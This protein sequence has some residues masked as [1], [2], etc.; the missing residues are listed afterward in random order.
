MYLQVGQDLRV[1]GRQ[2]NVQSQFVMQ[3]DNLADLTA[4]APRIVE[5]LKSVPL[6]DV[7]RDLQNHGLQ[8]LIH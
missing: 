7:S 8:S 2:S 3:G 4:F 6:V 5:E 1:G